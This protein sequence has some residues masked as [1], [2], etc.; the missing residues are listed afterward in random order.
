MLVSPGRRSEI[1]RA[2]TSLGEPAGPISTEASSE[3][4]DAVAWYDEQRSGLDA[5]F[6]DAVDATIARL[7]DWPGS[8]APVSGLAVGIEAEGRQSPDSPTTSPIRSPTIISVFWRSLTIAVRPATGLP[9][10]AGEEAITLRPGTAGSQSSSEGSSHPARHIDGSGSRS[11]VFLARQIS[12]RS[13][14]PW[15]SRRAETASP[16]PDDPRRTKRLG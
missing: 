13:V 6:I 15:S 5:A 9:G 12:S 7:A 10:R 16:A 2:T 3:F 14:T 8:G 1:D 4:E 11:R